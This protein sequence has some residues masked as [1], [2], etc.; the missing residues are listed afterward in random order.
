M[1]AGGDQ[2]REGEF[3]E[4]FAHVPVLEVPG[5]SPLPA[6]HGSYTSSLMLFGRMTWSG[7]GRSSRRGRFYAVPASACRYTGLA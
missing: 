1:P 6:S 3:T 4:S 2:R 7:H 5:C